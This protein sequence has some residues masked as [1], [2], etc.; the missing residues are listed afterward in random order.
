MIAATPRL[1]R[2]LAENP[3]EYGPGANLVARVQGCVRRCRPQDRRRVGGRRQVVVGLFGGK[4]CPRGHALDV[5]AVA[6][7]AEMDEVREAVEAREGE[8]V[9]GTEVV[10]LCGLVVG[11]QR[12]GGAQ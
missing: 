8:Q 10:E 5:A 4:E 3:R 2:V 6:A 7:W 9:R 12:E 1:R 11:I